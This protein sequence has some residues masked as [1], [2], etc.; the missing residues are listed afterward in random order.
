[1]FDDAHLARRAEELRVT[2][3]DHYRKAAQY[4][5]QGDK[6]QAEQAREAAVRSTQKAEIHERLKGRPWP[7]LAMAWLLEADPEEARKLLDQVERVSAEEL[8]THGDRDPHL[9]YRI[10]T[11]QGRACEWA[12]ANAMRNGAADSVVHEVLRMEE[13]GV[14]VN[15]AALARMT[16]ISRQTLHAR[17]RVARASE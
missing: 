15:I 16:G 10:A 14:E 6:A 9:E 13:L 8:L 17:L 11:L 1:M 7:A 5:A 2:A 12:M 3:G 4:D